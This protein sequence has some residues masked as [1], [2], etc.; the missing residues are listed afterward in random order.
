MSEIQ[1]YRMLIDGAWVP[2]SDG[3]VFDSVNPSTGQVWSRV[4]EATAADVDRAVQAAH[5][6]FKTGPWAAMLPNQ[7]GQMLRKLADLLA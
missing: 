6:A 4:P 3:A 2:A 5:R 7:R 1:T